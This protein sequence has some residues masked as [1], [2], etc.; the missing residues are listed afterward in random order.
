MDILCVEG[1]FDTLHAVFQER[2]INLTPGMVAAH[3]EQKVKTRE[4]LHSGVHAPVLNS[5]RSML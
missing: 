2:R 1:C 4:L 3:L 5:F